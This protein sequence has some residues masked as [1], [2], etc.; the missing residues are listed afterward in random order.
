MRRLTAYGEAWAKMS[1][2][3]NGEVEPRPFRQIGEAA[4]ASP[5]RP[6]RFS[7]ASSFSRNAWRC[8]TSEAGV[9]ELRFAQRLR[10]QSEDCCCLEIS[11]PSSS[12]VRSL[13]PWRSV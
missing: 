5:S 10:A 9:D 4:R 7:I 12:R 6:S 3:R 13:R 1:I 2:A 8:S 11:T